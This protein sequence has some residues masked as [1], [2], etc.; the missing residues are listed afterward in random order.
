MALGYLLSGAVLPKLGHILHVGQYICFSV[1]GGLAEQ[2]APAPS[3][4][5]A[6]QLLPLLEHM[7][8]APQVEQ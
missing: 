7:V 3:H 2:I 1:L 5:W 8:K 4:H 6:P